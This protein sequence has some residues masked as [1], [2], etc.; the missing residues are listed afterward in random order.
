[1]LGSA[2]YVTFSGIM[3]GFQVYITDQLINNDAQI[4]IS[5]RDEP[6]TQEMFHRVFFKG[7]EVRWIRP[8]TGRT[9]SRQLS[10]ASGW[11]RKLDKDARVISYAPQLTRQVIYQNGN[12]TIPGRIIGI[13]PKRQSKVT[14]IESSIIEGN[15]EDLSRGGSSIMLGSGILEK[16]GSRKGDTIQIITPQGDRYPLRIAGIIN[17]GNR[18][19]D[20]SIVYASITTV[21]R[22][23]NSPGEISDIVIRVRDISKAAEIA[24][25][26]TVFTKD[27]VESWDQTYES[28]LSVFRMQDIVRNVTSLT[29]ILVVAFG[30]YNILNMVVNQ[31]KKEIAILRSIGFDRGDTIK[32][33]VIQG[34]LLGFIGAVLGLSLGAFLNHLIDGLPIGGGESKQGT[35]TVK[36]AIRTLIISWDAMIFVKSFLLAFFSSF[37]ASFIPARAASKLSPV[38]IIRSSGT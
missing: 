35:G 32:L 14:T 22:V 12:T 13:D 37:I 3:L 4:R 17:T 2:G 5:P 10:N 27:K 6:L 19:L 36:P 28:I 34:V 30:I 9:D 25:Q 15:L 8:P 23:T 24:S 18:M 33:F 31:K 11:Y 21:Q 29:I 16:L 26:W 38:E 7:T 20:E 1:M